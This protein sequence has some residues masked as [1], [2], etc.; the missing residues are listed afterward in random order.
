M[1]A[2][3]FAPP[4][5]PV[6]SRPYAIRKLREFLLSLTDD[7]HSV[8][9]VAARKGIFCKGFSRWS[10]AELKQHFAGLAK[11]R[12]NLNR[13]QLEALAN[14]WELARQIVDHVPIACDAQTVEHDTCG[15]WDDFKNDDLAG[16]CHD[17]L[18]WEVKVT[19]QGEAGALT[20]P[21][22]SA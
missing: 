20:L 6:I 1:E 13:W 21:S 16:Y 4:P 15:G 9:E 5:H 2:E 19:D 12:P 7:D 8:C 11:R 22:R 17:L 14:K 10:D 18:G 3:A